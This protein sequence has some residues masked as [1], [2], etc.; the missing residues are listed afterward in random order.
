MKCALLTRPDLISAKG[1]WSP[2][3]TNRVLLEHNNVLAK[4][5]AAMETYQ[6]KR[7]NLKAQWS[8]MKEPEQRVTQWDTGLPDTLLRYIGS[9]SVS[10]P[11]RYP[12]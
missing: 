10:V 3:E 12:H 9:K 2:D 6:P 7:T 5:F 8:N 1:L 11:D 4:D